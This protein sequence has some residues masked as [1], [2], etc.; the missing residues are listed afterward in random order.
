M[1]NSFSPY[2]SNSQIFEIVQSLLHIIDLSWLLFPYSLP[3]DNTRSDTS[4]HILSLFKSLLILNFTQEIH[5]FILWDTSLIHI[6]HDPIHLLSLYVHVLEN[7]LEISHIIVNL[8]K[9]KVRANIY[10]DLLTPAESID[11]IALCKAGVVILTVSP[12][13]WV[14]AALSIFAC[15]DCI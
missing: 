6:F 1:Y 7:F 10:I 13:C 4:G 12:I 5:D 15:K 11:L 8:N 2:A 14:L 9:K 3:T